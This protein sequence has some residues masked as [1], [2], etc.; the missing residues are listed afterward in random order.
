M[1]YVIW[2]FMELWVSS[3]FVAWRVPTG[4]VS[5]VVDSLEIIPL[6][7]VFMAFYGVL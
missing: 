4:W 7:F 3:L 5:C 1:K 6:I 2:G